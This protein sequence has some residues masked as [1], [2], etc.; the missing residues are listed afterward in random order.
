[1]FS[2]KYSNYLFEVD[3]TRE[4]VLERILNHTQIVSSKEF[5]GFEQR[6]MYEI[7]T[8]K[9]PTQNLS[10]LLQKTLIRVREYKLFNY[11]V[12]FMGQTHSG[13]W[14]GVWTQEIL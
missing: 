7:E 4:A 5:D 1:M 6:L 13:D 10:Q 9:E 14:A 2:V 11:Y 8:F 3:R 12:Y